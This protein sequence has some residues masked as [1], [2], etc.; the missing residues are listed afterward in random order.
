MLLILAL[1]G[2]LTG[3]FITK[4]TIDEC[5]G[6][7]KIMAYLMMFFIILL[8]LNLDELTST[9]IMFIINHLT[10]SIIYLRVNKNA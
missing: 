6:K 10:G 3:Y 5:R 7:Q 4:L 2:L 8:L 9:L 1:T